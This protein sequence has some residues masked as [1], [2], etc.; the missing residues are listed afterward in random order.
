M[1]APS[2]PPCS[3]PRSGTCPPTTATSSPSTRGRH[4]AIDRSLEAPGQPLERIA[5]PPP[6]SAGVLSGH[7]GAASLVLACMRPRQWIKNAVVLAGVIFAGKVLEPAP[8][9]AA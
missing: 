6:G 8:L 4:V 9:A 5:E 3:A 7:V 2:C 1:R